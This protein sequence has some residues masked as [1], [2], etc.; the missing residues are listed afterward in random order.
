MICSFAKWNLLQAAI[1]DFRKGTEKEGTNRQSEG[2]PRK[3][4]DRCITYRAA[5]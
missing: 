1:P 5:V 4:H 2:V 3:H